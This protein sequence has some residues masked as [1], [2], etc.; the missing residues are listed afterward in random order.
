MQLFQSLAE[1]AG[2]AGNAE[3]NAAQVTRGVVHDN[4]VTVLWSQY[5]ACV[6]VITAFAPSFCV[7]LR[8]PHTSK[9]V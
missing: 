1:M 3:G 7:V 4:H 6:D 9:V 5:N 2:F 8:M